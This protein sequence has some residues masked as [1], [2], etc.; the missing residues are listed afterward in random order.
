MAL[1]RKCI[2]WDLDDTLWDGVC[3][4]GEVQV[5]SEVLRAIKELDQRG[6]LHSIASRGEESVALEALRD[7]NLIYFFLV[8]QI[9]WEPKPK[10]IITISK[11]LN[12]SLDSIAFIDDD[13]FELEQVS[14]MLPEVMTIEAD[15]AS[16]LTFIPD[17]CPEKVT[18]EG[19]RRRH[20]YLA[21]QKRKCAEYQFKTREAFL[22][23]C[24]MRLTV[25][26]MVKSDLPRVLELMSRTHQLNTIGHV[27]P[28][29]ELIKILNNPT[30]TTAINI[31]RLTDRF[32]SYGTIGIS[33]VETSNS[34]WMLK[35]LAISCR[36]LGRGVERA[37]LAFLLQDARE[38]G[39]SCAEAAYRDTGRNR[40]MRAL[41][42][43][44]GFRMCGVPKANG[45]QVFK[46]ILDRVPEVP[47]WIEIS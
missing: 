8:P 36:V 16:E 34:S 38:R 46:K 13:S 33:I 44:N 29:K 12:I 4:E 28:Q 47:T 43:M 21:E 23:S 15:R 37:V 17:F 30:K 22:K 25:R 3:L 2:V 5:R 7:N 10:N 19:Q 18:K 26:P 32:G 6:I 45:I 27:F 40:T 20:F 35:Y 41:Y 39:L 11:E 24:A 1:T 31:V 14:Y 9:N 42:Q